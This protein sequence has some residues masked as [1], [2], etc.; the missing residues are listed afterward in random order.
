MA[1]SMTKPVILLINHCVPVEPFLRDELP[2][3]MRTG[4]K[5]ALLPTLPP[6]TPVSKV[7]GFPVIPVLARTAIKKCFHVLWGGGTFLL[8]ALRKDCP[9]KQ[10]A[11]FARLAH[12]SASTIFFRHR[13]EK[14][15]QQNELH[16]H[17]LLIYTYWF[18]PATYAAFLLKE[19]FP[20]I[21]VVSRAHN[22]D[23]FPH[24]FPGRYLPLRKCCG[25]W[26]DSV[27][28]C[29]EEGKNILVQSGV[30]EERVHVS[31]LGVPSS[32]SIAVAS[33]VNTLC[34]V[35]C[36]NIRSVKR[37]FLLAESVATYARSRKSISI[38]WTH[39]GGEGK[40]LNDLQFKMER[41]AADIDNLKVTFTGQLH[42]D[43]VRNFYQ[44]NTVDVLINTSEDEG[45]PVSMMEALS[46]G[47]P[48][49]ATRVGGVPELVNEV[50]GRLIPRNFT[51]GD[52]TNALDAMVDFKDTAK[53]QAIVA[54][55]LTRF[56]RDK[57]YSEFVNSV[58]EPALRLSENILQNNELK[59]TASKGAF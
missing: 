52:F 48:V 29:S 4:A 19:T 28:P 15:I 25:N 43:D 20:H 35:S 21:R 7:E 54:F 5:I 38:Y 12:Y 42:P 44:C 59:K 23:I 18:S 36:S 50:T 31:H 37:L 17:P 14:Y 24:R 51:T 9:P 1:A 34:I 27:H 46:A 33:P 49:V 56:L 26:A 40:A 2:Y 39:L 16:K 22:I 58:I 32:K 8:H 13:L 45:L 57:N 10:L 6:A 47:V 30:T 3:L 55:F 41:E 11:C 53:R